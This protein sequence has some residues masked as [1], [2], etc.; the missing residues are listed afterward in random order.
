MKTC[1]Q[2]ATFAQCTLYVVLYCTVVGHGCCIVN[3]HNAC[4]IQFSL[5]KRKAHRGWLQCS[6]KHKIEKNTDVATQKYTYN[7]TCRPYNTDKLIHT[8]GG[9]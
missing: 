5:L 7:C 6:V 8:S 3:M 4:I 1:C 2:P 9:N